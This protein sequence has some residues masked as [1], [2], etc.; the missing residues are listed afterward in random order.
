MNETKHY[1][2][3]LVNVSFLDPNRKDLPIVTPRYDDTL[4]FICK[5]LRDNQ[6]WVEEQMLHHGAVLVR[7][8]QVKSA[9]DFE[10]AT[11]ALHPQLSDQYRGTSPRSLMKDTKYSFSAADVPVNYPI[12]QHL[13][14][15]F[16]N[17]PPRKLYF[18]CIKESK[19]AG[20]ETSLC[21]FRKVYKD[22]PPELRNKFA[23]K[24][25]TYTR[26]NKKVGDKFT[27]DVGALVSWTELFDTCDK[28]RVEQ[29]CE[30][31]GAP[32]IKWVGPN[33]DTFLQQ[34]TDEPF[35][36]HPD[37]GIPVW[38][39]HSQVFHWTTFPA[40][41]WFA[42]CRVKD[43]RIFFHFVLVSIYNIIMY[44]ILGFQTS[45]DTTF[46]DGTPITFQEM[47]EIRHA[48]HKNMIFSRW[49]KGDIM[50]IDNFSTSHGRQ[51]TYDKG[52]KVIVAWSQPQEKKAKVQSQEA[53]LID[54][55]TRKLS[56][57]DEHA[58]PLP[59]LLAATP[60]SSPE[61]SL[62][63]S[64]AAQHKMAILELLGR[65]L[66][67][68]PDCGGTMSNHKRYA[69]CPSILG[70]NSDSDFWKKIQ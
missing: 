44:G 34:W 50:C 13:E 60:S 35:Q 26:T 59:D 28:K 65:K 30:E 69:S 21:D 16:L 1:G 22:L 2:L 47:N 67:E 41:L 54:S 32:P 52:R 31:E 36:V 9:P 48:I 49:Q 29:I 58:E 70:P 27:F 19:N 23:S 62:T 4:A 7:G 68:E 57:S 53:A 24:K 39:N 33:E 66:P 45:L 14:M 51:P 8:F 61:S 40:E 42:F 3:D 37:S 56:T 43:I 11:L 63:E 10:S 38:F 18:G 6:S 20:G 17:A 5:W 15:S 25:I 64:E 46:G 55:S 12:A